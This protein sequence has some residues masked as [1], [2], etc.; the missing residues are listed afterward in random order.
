MVFDEAM[1]GV[2][3]RWGT[4]VCWGPGGAIVRY[5]H[6]V[7]CKHSTRETRA[8]AALA[9]T[10]TPDLRAIDIYLERA[11]AHSAELPSISIV[12]R[13]SA[14]GSQAPSV[15]ERAASKAP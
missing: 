6:I 2:E 11:G 5:T 10:R 15:S 4:L 13:R 8:K 1:P 12:R 7:A 9:P 3:A 14:S